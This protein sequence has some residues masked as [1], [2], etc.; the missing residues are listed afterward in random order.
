MKGSRLHVFKNH[1]IVT[2]GERYLMHHHESDS[3]LKG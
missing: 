3:E 1:A 2:N